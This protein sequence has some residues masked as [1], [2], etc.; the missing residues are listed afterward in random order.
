MLSAAGSPAG[1]EDLKAAAI[2]LID[3]GLPKTLRDL[4]LIDQPKP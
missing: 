3:R 4:Q 2:E 1:N